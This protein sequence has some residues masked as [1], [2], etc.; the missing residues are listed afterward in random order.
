MTHTR[1]PLRT[2]SDH[3]RYTDEIQCASARAIEAIR[4]KAREYN[5][6]N[7]QGIFDT[8]HVRRGDFQFK[9]T[10]VTCAEI[11]EMTKKQLPENTTLYVATDER[12][13]S[14]FDELKEHYHVLFLD[15]FDKELGE[16]NTNFYGTICIGNRC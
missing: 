15:D 11:Y 3:V 7:T 6:A 8:I 4:R 9:K 12:D 10:R 5:P 13:K 2:D 1:C 16:I 14:F